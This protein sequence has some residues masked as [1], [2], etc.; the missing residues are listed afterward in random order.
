MLKGTLTQSMVLV[1]MNRPKVITETGLVVAIEGILIGINR[2][3]IGEGEEREIL[4]TETEIEI[5]IGTGTGTVRNQ[6]GIRRKEEI[7]IKDETR[8][9][10]TEKAEIV[11]DQQEET[12]IEIEAAADRNGINERNSTECCV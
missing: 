1:G 7:E 11:I 12:G 4:E 2:I 10:K 8:G 3:E 5:E 6:I 9:R